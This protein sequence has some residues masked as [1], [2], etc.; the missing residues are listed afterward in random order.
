M[1]RANKMDN[2]Q[3]FLFI[4]ATTAIII[5][6]WFVSIRQ[7][8]HHAFYRFFSFESIA[9]MAILDYKYWFLNPFSVTQIIS[10]ILL[11]ACIPVAIIGFVL[12]V[13]RGKSKGV[14]EFEDTS[15]LVTT[16]MY[17]YIRHPLY[18]S[19]LLLGFG[20]FLKKIETIQ[21]IAVI[22]NT[23]ALYFT[24]RAEEREMIKKFGDQ[25]KEYMKK[26]KMFIPYLF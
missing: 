16:G 20:V 12:L 22:I 23:V 24:A 13:S 26:T 5:F 8:R 3:L 21:I 11:F 4:A 7:G 15:K 14:V 9:L 25:Y 10:W 1:K 19:L 18:C 6:S 2:I 17:K